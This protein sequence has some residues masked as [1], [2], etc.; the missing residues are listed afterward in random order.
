M[1]NLEWLRTLT[2]KELADWFYDE[3]LRQL[4]FSWSSSRG[5]LEHWLSEVRN[6][7]DQRG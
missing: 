5:G 1:T 2:A 4:Q 7:T 3:W 6:S